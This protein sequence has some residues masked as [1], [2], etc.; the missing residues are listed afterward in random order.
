MSLHFYP[1]TIKQVNQ[2]TANC[3]SVLFDVPENLQ[4]TFAYKHG[5]N[6]TVKTTINQQEVRRSYS[7]CSTP[8]SNE[9]RI[10]IKKL[11][12][13]LFSTFANEGLKEGDVLEVMPATGRF[14]TEINAHHQ[15]NYVAF[16]AGSGIT[17]I[18]SIIKTILLAEPKSTVTL[19]YGNKNVS[20]IIFKEEL[21][22][23]KNNF[24]QR[25]QLL[26]IL[27]QEGTDAPVFSGRINEEKLQQLSAIINYNKVDNFFVCGP[28]AMIFTIK[29]YLEQLGI[30][31]NKIHFEIFVSST[32]NLNKNSSKKIID[33]KEAT[34]KIVIKA[35]GRS[36]DFDLPFNSASILDGALKHGADLPFACKG[37]MCCTCKAKVLEGKV[38]MD[39]SWGLGADE[40]EQGYI[41]TCQS[42]P[43]T[44]KVVVDYD[45]K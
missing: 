38:E 42:H 40:I 27:S 16:A 23:I 7:L 33:S 39:V 28:E 43:I 22:A 6:I 8:L 5:Q 31:N 11:D 35:N 13:G 36:F 19:I 34:S 25:F 29:N 18:I 32:P 9:F 10:A 4:A 24:L 26:H 15:K 37:G 30:E 12:G 44:S 14:F 3:V 20:S 21:D 1:L 45:I 41:L 2:E 17:P